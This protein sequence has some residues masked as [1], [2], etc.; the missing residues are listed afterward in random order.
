MSRHGDTPTTNLK[1]QAKEQ[2]QQRKG[3]KGTQDGGK[4]QS[5]KAGG[6]GPVKETRPPKMAG[7]NQKR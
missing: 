1:A 4:G 6:T 3:D 2:A 7:K 5:G